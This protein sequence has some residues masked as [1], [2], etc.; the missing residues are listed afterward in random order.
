[1]WVAPFGKGVVGGRW[2]WWDGIGSG[3]GVNGETVNKATANVY[4]KRVEWIDKV[5]KGRKSEELQLDRRIEYLCFWDLRGK[6][7]LNRKQYEIF[8]RKT[9]VHP[10]N[11]A[12]DRPL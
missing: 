11:I 12:V 8:I 5:G 3:G 9:N 2:W 10:V 1:M 6:V 7:Q 4:R